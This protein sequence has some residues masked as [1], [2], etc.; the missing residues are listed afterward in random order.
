VLQLPGAGSVRL[1]FQ[2]ELRLSVSFSLLYLLKSAASPVSKS[3][4]ICSASCLNTCTVITDQTPVSPERKKKKHPLI[5]LQKQARSNSDRLADASDDAFRDQCE[6]RREVEADAHLDV[7]PEALPALPLRVQDAADGQGEVRRHGAAVQPSQL[8]VCLRAAQ[9][10]F[11][12]TS[13]MDGDE[14]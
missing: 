14:K 1:K 5:L 11:L 4:F 10:I 2:G 6:R 13:A 9:H 3:C 8:V 12:Q 7:A